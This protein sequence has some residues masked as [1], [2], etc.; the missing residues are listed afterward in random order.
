MFFAATPYAHISEVIFVGDPMCSWCYG[1]GPE[2]SRLRE[3]LKGVPFN[4]IMGGLRDGEIF[5]EA[6]LKNHLGYWQAVHEATGLPF[7]DTALSQKGFNY[8]TEPACRAVVTVRGLDK[9][10]EYDVY[11]ALQ[12]AFY[13]EGR[14][15]TQEDV[16]TEVVE[17]IGIDKT[18]FLEKFQSEAMIKVAAADKQKA[19]TY[20]VSS[21]PTLIIID[22]QGHMS[23]IRGYKKYEELVAL[24]KR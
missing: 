12:K 3:E 24:I 16:I 18:M 20:G 4:M 8:T 21:F 10:K 15:I 17:F 14:D 1:F 9:R 5:D 13:A 19:R 22:K 7:D 6:K 23:Q 11:S 2:L